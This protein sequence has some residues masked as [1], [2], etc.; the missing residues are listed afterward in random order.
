MSDALVHNQYEKKNYSRI[1]P[2][3]AIHYKTL[4]KEVQE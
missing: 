3:Q 4:D 1:S 2:F